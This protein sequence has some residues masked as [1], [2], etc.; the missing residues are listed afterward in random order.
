MYRNVQICVA[1]ST[2]IP[3]VHCHFSGVIEVLH[4]ATKAVDG[5]RRRAFPC[6]NFGNPSDIG[7]KRKPYPTLQFLL[8]EIVQSS[9][10]NRLL[11]PEIKKLKFIP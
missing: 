7:R 8:S 11:P 3:R 2:S 10:N 6:G 1:G 4:F 9:Q 5:D